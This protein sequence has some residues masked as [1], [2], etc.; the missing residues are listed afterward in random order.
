[1]LGLGFVLVLD[2]DLAAPGLGLGLGLLALF[3]VALLTPLGLGA[4]PYIRGRG[5]D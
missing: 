4:C 3:F 1:M 2:L 5:I